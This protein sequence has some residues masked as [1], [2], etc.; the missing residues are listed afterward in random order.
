MIQLLVSVTGAPIDSR[1]MSNIM[2]NIKI[3][4][5]IGIWGY[6]VV[7]QSALR[8]FLEH[9]SDKNILLYDT[10]P[11][12]LEPDYTTHERITAYK[13]ENIDEFLAD[14]QCILA[15]PGIDLRLY[16]MYQDKWI[17]EIDLFCMHWKK[18]LIAITGTVG[19]TSITHLVSTL[20][21]SA[22]Y[23]VATG[24]NIG[25]GMLDLLQTQES[26]DYAVIELSSF[27]LEFSTHCTP[28]YAIITNIYE[29]H[30]DRHG[31]LTQYITAKLR[32]LAQ[33][34]SDGIALLPASLYPHIK[35]YHPSLLPQCRFFA[36]TQSSAT[37]ADYVLT[38]DGAI[39]NAHHEK[40]YT[41]SQLP[42]LSYQQNWLIIA[43]LFN[44]LQIDLIQALHTAH[45]DLPDHRLHLITQIDTTAFYDDSK[46]TIIQA[47]YAAVTALQPHTILLILGGLS[48]GVDRTALLASF[49]NKVTF[50]ACFGA[51]AEALQH[52]CTA[53]HIPAQAYATLEDLFTQQTFTAYTAVLF[54]PGG[55]SFDLFKDYRERGARFTELVMQYKIAQEKHTHE[56]IDQ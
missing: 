32:I 18:P 51:E 39:H 2:K 45:L 29:N 19:K 22:G 49:K 33:L 34:P 12:I 14:A 56:L 43:A 17:T 15:S 11:I 1:C 10:K 30:L 36:D 53:A 35:H 31:T 6:G 41:L 52:A 38:P 9:Y 25:T 44:T 16:T 37:C 42:K 50:V 26:S 27:Q 23:T 28:S 55:A 20:L 5:T 48:K 40:L 7:G 24:G 13:P 47:T 54:S 46:A 21:Q 3:Y 4:N 8:F